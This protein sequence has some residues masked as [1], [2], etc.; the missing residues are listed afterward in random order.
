MCSTGIQK[1]W[2]VSTEDLEHRERPQPWRWPGTPLHDRVVVSL[3]GEGPDGPQ[4]TRDIGSTL[5]VGHFHFSLKTPVRRTSRQ[6]MDLF[7]D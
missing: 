1:A 5:V 4:W 7:R 6:I 2:S 3:G